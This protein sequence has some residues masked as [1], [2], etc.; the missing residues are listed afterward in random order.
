MLVSTTPGCRSR[1]ASRSSSCA[2]RTPCWARHQLQGL[3]SKFVRSS[4]PVHLTLRRFVSGA[5]RVLCTTSTLALGVNLPAYLVIV[6]STCFHAG[7][8]TTGAVLQMLGRAG[9]CACCPAACCPAPCRARKDCTLRSACFFFFSGIWQ[10]EARLS[11]SHDFSI[12]GSWT[13]P[14][15][16]RKGSALSSPR[17]STWPATRRAPARCRPVLPLVGAVLSIVRQSG[18]S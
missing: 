11:C 2:L 8:Y 7:S 17:P 5:C 3:C 1:T 10:S 4:H 12:I 18:L 13:G 14:A 15:S 16:T 9:R 6:K